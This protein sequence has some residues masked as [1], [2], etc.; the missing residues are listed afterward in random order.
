MSL[1]HPSA[2]AV[3]VVTGAS[4]GIGA[5]LARG[6]AA[7]GHDL[8]LVA[9]RA[10]RLEELAAE[11]RAAH[12]VDVLVHAADL[13]MRAARDRRARGGR[14]DRA[15]RSPG[16]ATTRATGWP[17][18]AWEVDQA[19]GPRPGRA[20]RRR[21]ARPDARRRAGHGASAGRAPCSTSPRAPRSSRSR[22]WRRT[23]R[24]RRSCT[25]FS[26]A[27]HAELAGT[28]VSVTT[29]Y[30][31][32]VAT[33]LR[34]PR[35]LLPGVRAAGRDGRRGRRGRAPGRRRDGRRPPLRHPRAVEQGQRAARAI[36]PADG[37]AAGAAVAGVVAAGG[38]SARS[39]EISPLSGPEVDRSRRASGPFPYLCFLQGMVRSTVCVLSIALSKLVV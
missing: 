26:E 34:R 38:G 20:E 1:P 31:G 7:R 17:G 8:V 28:G 6:L 10:D 35:R 24:R 9:R 13:T 19:R 18:R 37:A 33:G 15:R 30:P 23:P 14:R 21:A 32:P 25:R 11:L 3:V 4:S 27:L 5:E 39:V 12:G 29:L 36:R 2:D 22:G 16:S